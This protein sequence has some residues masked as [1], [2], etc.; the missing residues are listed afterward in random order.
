[1]PTITNDT[2]DKV[3]LDVTQSLRLMLWTLPAA[4]QLTQCD[5]TLR[6]NVIIGVVAHAVAQNS[7]EIH[8]TR[9]TFRGERIHQ[10]IHGLDAH[11]GIVVILQRLNHRLPD[12][13]ILFKTLQRLESL[14]AHSGIRIR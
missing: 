9:R 4:I 5:G 10:M 12:C 14:D 2:T 7:Y 13:W 1:M 8:R 11:A 3:C 6:A